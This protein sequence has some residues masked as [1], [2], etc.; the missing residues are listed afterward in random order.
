MEL[1]GRGV[2]QQMDLEPTVLGGNGV[3]GCNV[4]R[5]SWRAPLLAAPALLWLVATTAW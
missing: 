1:P 3:W 5:M 4:A 2:E